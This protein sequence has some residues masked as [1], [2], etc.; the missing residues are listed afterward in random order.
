MSWTL[1]DVAQPLGRTKLRNSTRRQRSLG[2]P[3]SGLLRGDQR[4]RPLMEGPN[5]GTSTSESRHR[6]GRRWRTRPS[7]CATTRQRCRHR[8]G[9]RYLRVRR[10]LRRI[11]AGEQR[12]TRQLRCARP[13][14][15]GPRFS[16]LPRCPATDRNGRWTTRTVLR[17][18]RFS[19]L[20]PVRAS[21][22]GGP[23]GC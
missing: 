19:I 18:N 23:W 22:S 10:G 7:R 3:R 6:G 2:Y 8:R 4:G 14:V 15:P 5:C 16:T 12:S 9:A 20:G 11:G 1:G 13:G 17:L 21:R